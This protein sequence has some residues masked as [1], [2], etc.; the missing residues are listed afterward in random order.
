MARVLLLIPSHSY[1]AT[2]FMAAADR[3]DVEVVVGSDRQPVLEHAAPGRSTWVDMSDVERGA[4]EVEAFARE[5]PLDTIIAVDDAG[6]LVG[7]RASARLGL[8]HNP[9]AAVAATRDKLLLRERLHA[10][11]LSSPP[12]VAVEL[13][14]NAHAAEVVAAARVGYPCVLKPRSLSASRGVIRADDA[15]GFIGAFERIRLL[16]SDPEL[17]A[18]C[19]ETARSVLVEGYIPGTEVSVEAL[20]TNGRLIVLA[21]FDKPDPLEGPFFEETIYVTPSRLPDEQQHAV[22][23]ATERAARALGLRDGPLHAEL[24]VNDDGVWP[25]DLAARSIGGLCS[26]TLSF[27]T[28]MSLEELILRHATR[29]AVPSFDR[30]GSASGVM[31]IPIP[32]GGTLQAVHGLAAAEAVPHVHEVTLTV[33]IG[34]R[35]VPLPEGGDYLGFIFARAADPATVEQA[36][37]DAHARLRF[38]VTA[39]EDADLAGS[40]GANVLR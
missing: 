30:E 3:L 11:G 26:R 22:L 8:A 7:A 39:E 6:A 10:G 15:A 24:R 27:G 19:G 34:Q 20:L 14:D 4:A 13:A 33:R 36:L 38:E 18:E 31:M 40:A 25:L 23:E 29:A 9:L 16:L 17:A 37:R 5:Y 35:V 32:A 28:G 12:F 2:D 21:V 1:R